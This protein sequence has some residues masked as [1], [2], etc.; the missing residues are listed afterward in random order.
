MDEATWEKA[1][2]RL[3]ENNLWADRN[4]KRQYLL[5]GFITCDICGHHYVGTVCHSTRNGELRYYK[6]DRK[7]QCRNLLSGK[8]H[9][10]TIRADWLEEIIWGDISEFIQKPEVVRKALEAKLSEFTLNYD[11]ELSRVEKRIGELIEAERR[12]LRLYADPRSNFS[13]EALDAEIKFIATSREIALKWKKEIQ[14]AKEQKEWEKR[15][16]EEV[17]NLL[18]RLKERIKEATFEEKRYAIEALLQ[19]IR[20]GRNDDGLPIV[21][22]IYA[23]EGQDYVGLHSTRMPVRIFRR[24][25]KTMHMFPKPHFSVSKKDQWSLA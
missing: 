3:K 25:S 22:I 10:P 13:R 12:L 1:Q 21:K 9:S 19:E 18:H 23:F 14:E 6:C 5:R 7:H 4:S 11:E 16:L 20:I 8:C 2:R 17:E 15:K 24:P